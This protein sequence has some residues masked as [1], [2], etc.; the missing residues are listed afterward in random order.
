LLANNIK[1][2]YQ[3]LLTKADLLLSQVRISVRVGV[4]ASCRICFFVLSLIL[5]LTL[6][7]TLTLTLILMTYQEKIVVTS[8]NKEIFILKEEVESLLESQRA[9]ADEHNLVRIRVS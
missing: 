1:G 9:V 3:D 4:W 2:E 7:L 5:I 8:L 6:T